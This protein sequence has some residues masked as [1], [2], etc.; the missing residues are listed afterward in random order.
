MVL[1]GGGVGAG[2]VAAADALEQG[3]VGVHKFKRQEVE[4]LPTNKRRVGV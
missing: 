4:K 1:I 3:K 2:F